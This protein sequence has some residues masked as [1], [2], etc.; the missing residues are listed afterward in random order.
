MSL[1]NIFPCLLHPCPSWLA[2]QTPT[3]PFLPAVRCMR[4]CVEVRQ[5]RRGAPGSP[6]GYCPPPTPLRVHHIV[7][8]EPLDLRQPAL[9]VV[10]PRGECYIQ[11]AIAED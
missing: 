5:A 6:D 4:R 7:L 3:H 2:H 11:A 8:P 1:G 10:T 9:C